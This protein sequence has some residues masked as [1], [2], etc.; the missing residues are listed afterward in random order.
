[1]RWVD[2]EHIIISILFLVIVV[3]FI[4]D[5]MDKK[6]KR[7]ELERLI[8][9]PIEVHRFTYKI[10]LN[11]GSS[12]IKLAKGYARYSFDSFVKYDILGY[13]TLK[14]KEDLSINTDG[15]TKVEMLEKETKTIKPIIKKFHTERWVE[16]LYT[17]EEVLE[18][19]IK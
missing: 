7:K 18:R 1:M 2:L 5:F 10:Y 16:D 14:L 3:I 8:T 9:T 15:I 13:E 11:D 4:I 17:H 6:K 12:Y 19:E